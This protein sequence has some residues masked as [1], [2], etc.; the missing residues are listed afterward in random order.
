MSTGRAASER[1][2][3]LRCTLSPSSCSSS[4]TLPRLSP[5][6]QTQGRVRSTC[7]HT[8]EKRLLPLGGDTRHV[9]VYSSIQSIETRVLVRTLKDLKRSQ[10]P[11][12]IQH[13]PLTFSCSCYW[14]NWSS[15]LSNCNDVMCYSMNWTDSTWFVM[16]CFLFFC[17]CLSVRR[18]FCRHLKGFIL[19]H[20]FL[21]E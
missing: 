19:K 12:I 4:G 11:V 2:R 3:G 13:S 1:R 6:V 10:I 7:R 5:R 20:T 18:C 8:G 15:C 9:Y 16:L 14:W 17:S 21:L